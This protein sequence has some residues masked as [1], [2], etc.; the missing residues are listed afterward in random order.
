M[1]S[2]QGKT[3][4]PTVH[5]V[6]GDAMSDGASD[7]PSSPN[8]PTIV[9]VVLAMLGLA[10][11]PQGGGKP[12]DARPKAEVIA[13]GAAGAFEGGRDEEDLGPL[14]AVMANIPDLLKPVSSTPNP[15]N[16]QSDAIL[17][18]EHGLRFLILLVPDP[19][20][21]SMSHEFDPTLSAA[22]R[23]TES[24][25]FLARRWSPMPGFPPTKN[26]AAQNGSNPGSGRDK[27]I[28]STTSAAPSDEKKSPSPGPKR[29]AAVLSVPTS[30]S[31]SDS[32]I[33]LL[34]LLVP[35]SPTWGVD[36][37]RLASAIDLIDRHGRL[38]EKPG[39]SDSSNHVPCISQPIRIIGPAFSG[40]IDSLAKV[41][42]A[43]ISCAPRHTDL[44]S[45]I[46]YNGRSVSPNLEP[47]KFAPPGA[48]RFKS[49]IYTNT[50][51][52]T[53]FRRYLKKTHSFL[54]APPRFA[55]LL[56]SNTAHGQ[57]AR[58]GITKDDEADDEEMRKLSR[59]VEY[60]SFPLNI[61]RIRE[62][63]AARGYF[64]SGEQTKLQSPDRFSPM[65]MAGQRGEGDLIPVVS[66]GPSAMGG[67]LALS[68]SLLAIERGRFNWAAITATNTYDRLFLAEKVRGA[69]P[70]IRLC[71][72][73][74][75]TLDVHH[76]ATPYLRGTIVFSTYPLDPISQTW[77]A[78]P[79]WQGT[80]KRVTKISFGNYFEE[81]IYN[82]TVAHLSDLELDKTPDLLD[83]AY[84]AA[85]PQKGAVPSVWISVIGQRSLYPLIVQEPDED[86]K[87]GPDCTYR[88]LGGM[89]I[90]PQNELPPPEMT[91][92]RL[93]SAWITLLI[94]ASF[95]SIV[96]SLWYLRVL[97]PIDETSRVGR[98]PTWAIASPD[99][100][101]VIDHHSLR[102]L[103][104]AGSSAA[105][106]QMI[107]L[108][109]PVWVLAF[110]HDV[111]VSAHSCPEVFDDRTLNPGDAGAGGLLGRRA[112]SRDFCGPESRNR[113]RRDDLPGN[114]GR[115]HA[116]AV[117]T[118]VLPGC[119]D[120][121]AE[122]D[123]RPRRGEF[124]SLPCQNDTPG[125]RRHTTDA[126]SV[127][128][129]R[130]RGCHDRRLAAGRTADMDE[131]HG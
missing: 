118:A 37:E 45:V 18:S 39:H 75:S 47:L 32:S 54:T 38:H 36:Q 123:G 94:T 113:V 66:P 84:P 53:A 90:A 49:T 86:W 73:T 60:F 31:D 34:T 28:K 50:Q 1:P 6:H 64:S 101:Q 107:L 125:Q 9:V 16:S 63:Y 42:N 92:A 117:R 69:C 79:G 17:L 91:K 99:V 105:L 131:C 3:S 81:G 8:M 51:M 115:I 52:A 10:T 58:Q 70:D 108:S 71:F 78:S 4:S 112:V 76:T 65:E 80:R 89:Y 55:V 44:P 27:K 114:G 82:A 25:G 57:A 77:T 14:G 7:K 74:A 40:S 30:S 102:K 109:A 88:D 12:S 24:A 111:Q 41:L 46:I 100:R 85:A 22:L 13:A 15:E 62:E 2:P 93:D 129:D 23:A 127:T 26:D 87:Y 11:F 95:A 119:V 72:M 29:P 116:G 128:G 110:R 96:L 104:A 35:E 103:A 59:R 19:D 48:I 122:V 106:G 121:L 20:Q 126:V 43:R 67:E 5:G 33:K 83:Y 97:V 56:E 68:Q 124:A 61:S 120:H 130:G 98:W 21:T